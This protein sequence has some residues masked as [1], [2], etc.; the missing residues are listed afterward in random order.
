M[1]KYKIIEESKE[2]ETRFYSRTKFVFS[3][4]LLLVS[5]MTFFGSSYAIFSMTLKGTKKISFS[6]GTFQVT[7]NEKETF[8]L[9][10]TSPM[11]SKEAEELDPYEFTITNK[12]NMDAY[13][14][15]SLQEEGSKDD[16]QMIDK[17]DLNYSLTGTDGTSLSG[18]LEELGEKPV[19]IHQKLLTTTQKEV[20]YSLRMWVSEAASNDV[21][22]KTYQ[23]KIGIE[24]SQVT[25]TFSDKLIQ[26]SQLEGTP[27]S[28]ETS[29]NPIL[30]SQKATSINPNLLTYR[31]L[32]ENPQNYVFWNQELW[33]VLGV[34]EVE[35][36]EG[37]VLPLVKLV[38]EKQTIPSSSFQFETYSSSFYDSLDIKEQQMIYSY[39]YPKEILSN[40]NLNAKDLYQQEYTLMKQASISYPVGILSV[41]D[42]LYTYANGYETNCFEN[43]ENC[44]GHSFLAPTTREMLFSSVSTEEERKTLL[45]KEGS[46]SIEKSEPLPFRAVVYLKPSVLLLKGTGTL[47]SPYELTI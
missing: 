8:S 4:V 16:T 5:I 36:E 39:P 32:G 6:V 34:F 12:G 22:G 21:Q 35:M 30:F 26:K 37:E 9:K 10:A 33:R 42:Y 28:K 17:S 31:Y 40:L 29:L 18:N 44:V 3:W 45:S 14:T 27:Y 47:D 13:Y 19:L 24:S 1:A 43:G 25:G 38:R 7:L 23:S 46:V 15:L 2:K 20:T 11:S 41:S